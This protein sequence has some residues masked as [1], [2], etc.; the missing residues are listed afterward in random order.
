MGLKQILCVDMEPVAAPQMYLCPKLDENVLMAAAV[1]YTRDGLAIP[2]GEVADGAQFTV[3]PGQ[4]LL[5]TKGGQITE[6]CAQ[7]GVYLYNRAQPASFLMGTMTRVAANQPQQPQ[8]GTEQVLYLN[9]EEYGANAFACPEKLTFQN[10]GGEPVS[11]MCRGRY[12]YRIA[13]PIL[14]YNFAAAGTDRAALGEFLLEQF[15]TVLQ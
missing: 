1:R 5:L 15:M 13:N 9:G 4:C 2:D 8:D 14:F 6:V 10:D 11:L 12:C 7:P 3:A